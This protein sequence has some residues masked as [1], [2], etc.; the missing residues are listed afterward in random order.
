MLLLELLQPTAVQI[1]KD[2]LLI[3]A[4]VGKQ[5]CLFHNLFVADLESTLLLSPDIVAE[6]SVEVRMLA[7]PT[8]HGGVFW[9]LISFQVLIFVSENL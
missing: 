4:R 6:C 7:L 9:L 5:P 3:S 2:T 1:V 8:F